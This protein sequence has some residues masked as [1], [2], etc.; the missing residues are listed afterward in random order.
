MREDVDAFVGR[1]LNT[2]RG[3]C[4][5]RPLPG[6]PTAGDVEPRG[7]VAGVEGSEVVGAA[8]HILEYIHQY[9][10]V[11]PAPVV[12]AHRHALDVAGSQ[13]PSAVEEPPLDD[14]GMPDWLVGVQQEDMDAAEGVLPIIVGEP[15]FGERLD[16]QLPGGCQR[17]RVNGGR[18]RDKQVG[19]SHTMV[20]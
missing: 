10:A 20:A 14:S 18:M 13:R 17:C 12:G 9:R 1:S 2:I 8:K 15:F 3:Q 4:R 7:S 6:R 19:H 16:E 5:Q 11:A